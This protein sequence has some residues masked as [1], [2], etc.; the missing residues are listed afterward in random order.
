MQ[1]MWKFCLSDFSANSG[2]L[3]LNNFILFPVINLF[4]DEI[5]LEVQFKGA[6]CAPFHGVRFRRYVQLDLHRCYV[7]DMIWNILLFLTYTILAVVTK[8]YGYIYRL[9][10]GCKIFL[11]PTAGRA[12]P[13]SSIQIRP[14]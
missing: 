9:Y 7:V 2:C 12:K 1:T 10:S 13:Q 5:T 6:Q 3:I 14:T 8:D 4:L 11:R